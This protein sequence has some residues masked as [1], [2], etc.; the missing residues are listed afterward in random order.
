MANLAQFLILFGHLEIKL[1]VHFAT[2]ITQFRCV[3]VAGKSRQHVERRGGHDEYD[4]LAV[5]AHDARGDT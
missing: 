3:V 2:Y 1:Y 5:G 4:R